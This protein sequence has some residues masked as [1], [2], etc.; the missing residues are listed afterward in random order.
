MFNDHPGGTPIGTIKQGSAVVP[1]SQASLGSQ[2]DSAGMV[3]DLERSPDTP[4]GAVPGVLQHDRWPPHG[5]T[6][7]VPESAGIDQNVFRALLEAHEVPV[8]K[9]D[10]MYSLV[11]EVI[12]RT[13]IGPYDPTPTSPGGRSK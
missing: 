6:N 3:V 7:Y 13:R 10:Q 2:G 5:I 1:V 4:I 12:S 8:D 9:A 11:Q